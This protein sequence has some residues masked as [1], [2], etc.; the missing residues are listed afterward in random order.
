MAVE[1]WASFKVQ[2]SFQTTFELSRIHCYGGLSGMAAFDAGFDFAID[3]RAA[4]RSRCRSAGG[5]EDEGGEAE[6]GF[7]GGPFSGGKE[8]V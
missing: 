5:K 2:F 6:D 4:A 8:V 7:H 1:G 3:L